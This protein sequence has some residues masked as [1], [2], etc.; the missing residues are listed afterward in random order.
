MPKIC[1]YFQQN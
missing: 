1:E